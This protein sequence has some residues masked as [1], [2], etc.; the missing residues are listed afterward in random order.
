MGKS[1]LG[2]GGDM[3]AMMRNP[4]QLMANMQKWI[5]PRIVKQLGGQQNLM[6]LVNDFSKMEN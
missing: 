6:N 4:K 5:D 3:Q 2:K 1:A